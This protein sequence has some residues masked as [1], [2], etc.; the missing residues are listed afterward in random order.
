MVSIIDG[1]KELYSQCKGADA[2]RVEVL[3][4]SGSDRRYFRVFGA[5]ETVIATHG[6]N[7]RE[8]E[9]FIY[10]SQHFLAKDCPLQKSLQ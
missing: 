10:F 3:P 7:I 1:I 6:I 8:N 4:Q 5:G 9:A 2:D